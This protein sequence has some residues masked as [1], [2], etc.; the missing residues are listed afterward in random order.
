MDRRLDDVVLPWRV[1]M[2]DFLERYLR[3]IVLIAG[4]CTATGFLTFVLVEAYRQIRRI[5]TGKKG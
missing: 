1:S 4:I 2:D 3:L 5:L